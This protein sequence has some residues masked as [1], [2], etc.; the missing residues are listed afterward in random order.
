MDKNLETLLKYQELDIKLRRSLDSLEKSEAN[1]KMEQARSEFNGAKKTVQDSEKDAES[2]LDSY[3]QTAAQFI[4]LT[5][6]VNDLELVL[7][8]AE[9]EDDLKDT[10]EQ[11][12]SL[13]N[14]AVALEKKLNDYKAAAE[15]LVK[16]YQDANTVGLKMRDCFNAAKAEYTELIKAAEPEINALKKKLKDLESQINADTLKQYK[17][18]TAENKYPAFVEV[19]SSDG[20]YSCQGCGLQLS[21]KNTSTLNEKGT[22]ICETCRRVIYKE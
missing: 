21:Q 2:M 22:C 14:K 17:A 9:P 5:N 1:K 16:N 3:E 19:H 12:E 11:L 18:I 13:K 10:A 7:E 15:K 6:R 20:T 4:E 8:N